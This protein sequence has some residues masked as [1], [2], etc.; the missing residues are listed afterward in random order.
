M[1]IQSHEG[2]VERASRW[3]L[4]HEGEYT[5][6]FKIEIGRAFGRCEQFVAAPRYEVPLA[7]R[8]DRSIYSVGLTYVF[9]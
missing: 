6:K 9:T 3:K 5:S 4:E 1:K 2:Y 7:E 8:S